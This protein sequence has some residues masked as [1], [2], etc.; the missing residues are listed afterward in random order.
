[1]EEVSASLLLDDPT[2]VQPG[3]SLPAPLAP[4]PKRA[5]PV[6]HRVPFGLPHLP[7]ATPGP[8]LDAPLPAPSSEG[9]PQ[10]D[11][12]PEPVAAAEPIA[13]A[14]ALTPPADGPN[15]RP[16]VEASVERDPFLSPSIPAPWFAPQTTEPVHDDVEV[17]ALP[18]SHTGNV[19]MRAIE[20]VREALAT[21]SPSQ[22]R[23]RMAFLFAVGSGGLIVGIG[24]VALILSL[25]R[26]ASNASDAGATASESV[27]ASPAIT[28]A[29]PPASV[30]VA[31]PAPTA[32][33]EVS[34]RPCTVTG[35][36]QVV[37]PTA[38][39]QAGI[40]VRAVGNQV[41]LGFAPDE[42]RAM[43]FLLDPASLSAL[44]TVEAASVDPIRRVVPL[45]SAKVPLSVAVDADREGDSVQGRRTIP[46]DPP[47]QIGAASGHLVWARP[48]GAPGGTLWP[49]EGEGDVEA[50]RG[51]V[52]PA[53]D[54]GST[55]F[56]L[57]HANAIWLGAATGRDALSPHGGLS[58]IAGSGSTVGSPAIAINEGVVV[59]AWADRSSP[60]DP[61]RLKW[62]HFKAGEAPGDPSTFAPPSGGKGTQAMSPGVT[63][64]PGGR[65]LLVWTEGP[66]TGHDV[67]ALTLSRDGDPIGKPLDISD[68]KANAGQ[69]QGAVN[70][71]REGLVAFLQSTDNGFQ[72][73]ATPISCGL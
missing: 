10:P 4:F 49:I 64:V 66:V 37:A 56:A 51:A 44:G 60:T 1:M 38:T 31:P 9:P 30:M 22:D 35:S 34:T 27:S 14:P 59:A 28:A 72:V 15:E 29:A 25:M 43:A 8:K 73:V 33:A 69:G 7:P 26:R 67:R 47:L 40:E 42:H 46:I 63:A 55:A 2:V 48:G 17:T 68:K 21:G 62:V 58:R 65:F 53:D 45:G 36:P 70:G 11:P 24:V 41:A 6:S 20:H 12:V 50:A 19:L 5:L 3:P 39:I 61:W 71:S 16:P 54:A 52:E 18:R 13:P 57:R 32:A 23:R